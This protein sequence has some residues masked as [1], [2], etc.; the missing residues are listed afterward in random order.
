MN[1]PPGFT[2]FA[3]AMG[4]N[5]YSRPGQRPGEPSPNRARPMVPA[6]P[7]RIE[8]T[9]IL[10]PRKPRAW[11]G[12]RWTRDPWSE[13]HAELCEG[14]PPEPAHLEK[15][16]AV[17]AQC[18]FA[19]IHARPTDQTLRLSGTVSVVKAAIN[20]IHPDYRVGR[21]R[22]RLRRGGLSLPPDMEAVL[23][24]V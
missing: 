12:S 16:A 1:K 15:L 14:G 3:S 23:E 24:G 20:A 22:F 2:T 7:A 5:V 19:V 21:F 9:V 4:K 17:A 10:R 13:T 18:G 6:K 8:I 11:L